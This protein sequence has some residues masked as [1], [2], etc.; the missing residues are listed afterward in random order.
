[1]SYILQG[2]GA[3]LGPC[4]THLVGKEIMKYSPCICLKCSR[5]ISTAPE[6]GKSTP[7]PVT[8]QSNLTNASSSSSQ[9]FPQLQQPTVR[10]D[11]TPVP[12]P[13]LEGYRKKYPNAIFREKYYTNF[14][15]SLPHLGH[16]NPVNINVSFSV[17]PELSTGLSYRFLHTTPALEK[18][19]SSK[20]EE[21]VIRLKERQDEH[22]AEQSKVEDLEKKIASVIE[23]EDLAVKVNVE[24][25]KKVS[26]DTRTIWEKVVAE[27][28]HYYSGFKLLFLDVQVSSKIIWRIANGKTLSRRENRQLVRTVSDLF[29]LLP[30]S[31]FILIPFME[32][33]L[34]VAL[35]LFPGMLPSTFT[36]QDERENKMR[37]ALKAKLEYARFLQKTLDEMGPM[38]KGHRSQSASDFVH[39]YNSVKKTGAVENQVT[40]KDILKFSKL[41]E[42]EIT[43]DNMTRGQLVAICRL[44]ELTPIGTNA[45]LR[46]QIEMQ[47][48][49]L[50][51]DDVIIAKEGMDHMTVGELQNACKDRGMR[52]IGITQEKLIK[53][54]KQW[55]ELS[56]NEK[57]PPSLLL[58]SRTLYLPETVAP[59]KAI[60]ASISALPEAVATGAKAKIGE[61]EGKIENVTRLE[62]IKQEQAKIEEEQ[63]EQERN[64]AEK[65]RKAEEEKL[66]QEKLAQQALEKAIEEQSLGVPPAAPPTAESVVT[67]ATSILRRATVSEEGDVSLS[68]SETTG[69]MAGVTFIDTVQTTDDIHVG[70]AEVIQ[71]SAP[72]TA[73]KSLLAQELSVE[74]LTALRS[75]IEAISLEKGKKFIGEHEVLSEL[76]QE[77]VDYEEDLG[78]MK[79]VAESTGRKNLRQTKGAARLFKKMNS[80]LGKADNV[81]Q[82]LE[83]RQEKLKGVI[84]SLDESSEHEEHLVTVQD[85][86][87]AVKGLQEVPDSKMLERISEVVASMDEDSDGVVKLEHVN[88][89]IEILGSDN[90]ELSGKQVKQII[91]L[92]G[93]E[94]ML[95]V[96]SRIEK[97]LGKMPVVKNKSDDAKQAVT[98]PVIEKD[99]TEK[100]GDEELKDMAVEMNTDKVEEHIAEMFSRPVS[101]TKVETK[102]E[103]ATELQ[104][105]LQG[106]IISRLTKDNSVKDVTESIKDKEEVPMRHPQKNGSK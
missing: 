41:F 39:F 59:E 18:K 73:K 3:I 49:K 99:I 19:S 74:D 71:E 50:K 14:S 36:S 103:T 57:V 8:I 37:R 75:A 86:L 65:K 26:P 45:F 80:L 77:M 63:K 72:K 98:K 29:R 15:S 70:R 34:P 21:T 32:L 61:K 46:F 84:D 7:F 67:E 9:K 81:V 6:R 58:L 53:Q 88:K 85:L 56:T 97:I 87:G 79:E 44:L 1:M 89:V 102:V 52:A 96:E 106:E 105:E 16:P 17:G 92:I 11:L 95:E 83:M 60:E 76:K 91:D 62:I 94:E 93:K 55:I 5:L 51:A 104:D 68:S 64:L 66:K 27:A 47:L 22:I 23:A 48:R 10:G 31:V 28:K 78:E 100:A 25:Q 35:K 54:L 90:V 4:L 43:L 42:D 69:A 13:P 12:I 24:Q 40:N 33:L 82:N 2:S 101:E 30:F 38:D 20:V